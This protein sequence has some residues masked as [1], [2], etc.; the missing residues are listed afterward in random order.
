MTT[1]FRDFDG[2]N[3]DL[4][5]VKDCP[6]RDAECH[7]RCKAFIKWQKEHISKKAISD[8]KRRRESDFLR[9]KASIKRHELKRYNKK[10]VL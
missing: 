1:P 5:C 9:Y 7:S 8:E 4:P 10:G 2:R 3:K 6:G